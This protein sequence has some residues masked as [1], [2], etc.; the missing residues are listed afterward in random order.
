MGP[1]RLT[2]F[3]PR[4]WT[5]DIRTRSGAP[6]AE[7]RTCGPVP[8]HGTQSSAVRRAVITHLADHARR[9]V[10][11]SHLRTCQCGHRGCPWHRPHRGC[12]GPVRLALTYDAASRWWR[13]TDL[14]HQCCQATVATT[15][16]PH[17]PVPA[18]EHAPAASPAAGSPAL[19]YEE[20]LVWDAG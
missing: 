11:P 20:P 1:G 8:G 14:C 13:L 15:S 6:F 18:G 12:T 3:P 7:C 16:V 2:S 4:I 10:T 19:P 9:D 17:V 5:V